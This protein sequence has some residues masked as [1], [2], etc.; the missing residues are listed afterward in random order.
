MTTAEYFDE[1][2]AQLELGVL[3]LLCRYPK[4]TAG[5]MALDLKAGPK[6]LGRILESMK[7]RGLVTSYKRRWS[8]A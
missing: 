2:T 7:A 6:E 4:M 1:R 8:L 5:V 3:E